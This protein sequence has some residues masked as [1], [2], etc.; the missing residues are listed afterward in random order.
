MGGILMALLVGYILGAWSWPKAWPWI[1]KHLPRWAVGAPLL[2]LALP[3]AGQVDTVQVPYDSTWTVVDSVVTR[4]IT[5]SHDTT[6]TFYRDSIITLPPVDTVTPPPTGTHEPKGG[7]VLASNDWFGFSTSYPPVGKTLSNWYRYAPGT[8]GRHVIDDRAPDDPDILEVWFGGKQGQGPEHLSVNVPKGN[9]RL[10][11][12]VPVY[13]PKDYVGSSSGVQKLFHVW[14]PSDAKPSGVGGSMAVPAIFGVLGKPLQSQIRVQGATV[15]SAHQT[16]F[17]IG[18]RPMTRGVWYRTEWL[19]TMNSPGQ[20]NGTATM[21]Q[22]GVQAV[23]R[24]G[25]TY[26]RAGL[27]WTV[28][29]LNPTYGGTGSIPPGTRLSYGRIRVVAAP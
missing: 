16:S 3:L 23:H 5:F 4:Q 27:G 7:I 17:N 28:V 22:D 6:A 8:T 14:A 21:W 13:V 11:I 9:S 19:L 29:Q 25:I 10:Y 26:S 12:S 24:T 2:L 1:K 20:A 15:T 18:G